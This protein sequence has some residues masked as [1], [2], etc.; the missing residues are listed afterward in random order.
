MI[1]AHPIRFTQEQARVLSSVTP[2][3]WRHWR[4]VIDYLASKRGKAARFSLGDVV[5]LSVTQE[6]VQ[7]FGI[8][9]SRMSAGLDHLFRQFEAIRPSALANS[10][11]LIMPSR[12]VLTSAD[13]SVM[14][15]GQSAVAVACSP[16]VDRLSA[17]TFQI[18][19]D[20]SQPSLPFPPTVMRG[21]G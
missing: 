15:V 13:D 17:E 5:A 9:V 20:E 12:T 2:E 8:S 3:A 11:A 18:V 4:G 10:V 6:A 21:A 16:I 14:A 19:A 1:V 7:G